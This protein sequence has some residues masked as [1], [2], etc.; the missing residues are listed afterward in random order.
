VRSRDR[1]ALHDPRRLD[2]NN[3]HVIATR[4]GML[5]IVPTDKEVDEMEQQRTKNWARISNKKGEKNG[6]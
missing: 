2:C 1:N 6:I 5:G 3:S 4:I